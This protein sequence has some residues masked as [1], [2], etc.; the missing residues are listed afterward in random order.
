MEITKDKIENFK[1]YNADFLYSVKKERDGNYEAQLLQSLA[2]K[3]SLPQFA[4]HVLSY[5]NKTMTDLIY[6]ATNLG[7]NIYYVNTD[8]LT[9][10]KDDFN[11]LNEKYNLPSSEMGKFSIEVE[12]V[13]FMT[14][15]PYKNLHIL[16]DGTTRVRYPKPLSNPIE[17]FEKQFLINP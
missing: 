12:S 14:L 9:L 7:G 1:E 17:F 16:K 8:C 15:A 4:C 13:A 6:S 11:R 5:S 10:T 2:L 3:Y